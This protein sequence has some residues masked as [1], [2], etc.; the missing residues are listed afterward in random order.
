MLRSGTVRHVSVALKEQREQAGGT[1]VA[2]GALCV[3]AWGGA[4]GMSGVGVMCTHNK[5]CIRVLAPDRWSC[6]AK[7]ARS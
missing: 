4:M 7:S 1:R 2:H 3:V 6:R 5:P